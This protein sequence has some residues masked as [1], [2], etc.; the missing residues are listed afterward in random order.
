MGQPD[1]QQKKAEQWTVE[2]YGRQSDIDRGAVRSGLSDA[3]C[4]CDAIAED[5]LAATKWGKGHTAAGL[6]AA[7]QVTAVGNAIEAL[8]DRILVGEPA[9]AE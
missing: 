6:K 9:N 7:A 2:Y 3:V 1:T 4:L 5:I 8:R